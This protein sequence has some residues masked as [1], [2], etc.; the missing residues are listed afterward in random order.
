MWSTI[1][2]SLRLLVVGAL[3]VA[4]PSA[5]AATQTAEDGPN[6]LDDCTSC[7]PIYKTMAKCQTIKRPGGIGDEITDCVCVPNP[8]GWYPY[9]HQCRDCLSSAD[10][11]FF[12]N[13]ASMM[14]Q[15]LTSCTNAGGNVVSDGESICASN[16]MWELCASL[17]DGEDS[18]ALSWASFERFSDHSR[19][20]NVTQLLHL[21]GAGSVGTSGSSSSSSSSSGKTTATTAGATGKG[22]QATE[23]GSAS[24]TAGSASG[25]AAATTG[26]GNQAPSAST[27]GPQ[28]ATS[29]DKPSAAAG[30]RQGSQAG[31]ALG[32][33]VVAGV[34]GLLV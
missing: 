28:N 18:G 12:N 13:L 21:E 14:T 29:T 32:M 27:T 33:V 31:Y 34:V 22:T 1:T 2:P 15:L 4:V 11:D 10:N 26:T 6:K 23:S 7:G 8:D 3:L 17:K 5:S 30:L 16:A 24:T 9:I 20:S 25:G 19:D